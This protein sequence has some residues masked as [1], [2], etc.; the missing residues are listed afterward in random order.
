MRKQVQAIDAHAKPA[1]RPNAL[2]YCA[3]AAVI[4]AY[5]WGYRGTVGHEQ[6]AMVPGAL[7]G[8]ALCLGSGRLDWHR[9]AAIVGL[10]AAV[11]WAWGGSISY[12]E[13]TLYVQSDSFPDVLYG[14]AMLFFLGGLW[15]GCGGAV[16]G[17]ALTEARSEL[18]CLVRPL[19]VLATAL[20]LFYLY[21]L[22]VPEHNEAYETLTVRHFHDGDWLSATI[23][24]VVSAV[25]WL[26]R[27]KD[28]RG[29]ALFFWAAV[30]WWIGYG[31]LTKLGGLRLAPLHRSESWGGV[32]G[33]LVVLMIYLGR[34]QNRAALMLCLYG[35]V[36]GGL[37]FAT[38]VFLRHPLILKLGPLAE[39]QL[40]IPTWRFAEDSFGFLMGLA[41]ALGALRLLHGR[42]APP[43]EDVDRSWTDAFSV[44]V[45]AVALAWM[46]FRRHTERALTDGPSAEDT[47]LL[48]LP[49]EAWYL[50]VAALLT[51]PPLYVLHRYRHGDR[52]LVPQ[53]AFGKG[54][55]V[56]VLILG[57]TA[58]MQLLD[59]HP[60]RATLLAN[61]S[62]WLPAAIAGCLLVGFA[63]Q[64][65][66][67]AGS[68]VSEVARTDACWNVG[69]R[70]ALVWAVAPLVLLAYAAA[71]TAMQN[72]NHGALG[73]LRF[74][75]D[76][77]WR[78]TSRLQGTWQAI[79]KAERVGG[80]EIQKADLPL[81]QLQFDAY[82]NVTATLHS[83]EQVEAHRWFLKNQYIWLQWYGKSPAHADRAE[84]P[85][86][87]EGNRLYIAWPPRE[88]SEGYLVLE[89][90]SK[91]E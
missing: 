77:Y 33:V 15:A 6:G 61:L 47:T 74:G 23:T 35:C 79:G 54:A 70:Y 5:G 36:G 88:H 86:Q 82:R 4:M 31:L 49:A 80:N 50:L 66:H 67:G 60:S 3:L 91:N 21:F 38:A 84:V 65:T 20:L 28:R 55:A 16:L 26:V 19:I 64:S 53:S 87:F 69:K 85:L 40:R 71:T 75:P 7:L 63:P 37:A 8:L 72:E 68:D 43:Q 57:S 14:Y 24:L 52:S 81:D 78:Q 10:F 51:F 76:A 41:M 44:F 89:R 48:G 39:I 1:D 45:V 62:L 83:G 73:R 13:Q 34:R 90:V 46:N 29:T 11:G 32:L 27:P 17:L 30:A 42:L 59:E 18:E 9:R 12:M 25:Y 56:T 2:H 58:A 22:F